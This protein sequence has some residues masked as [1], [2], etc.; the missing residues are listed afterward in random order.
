MKRYKDR[1]ECAYGNIFKFDLFRVASGDAAIYLG[2]FDPKAKTKH[3]FTL[4]ELSSPYLSD[5]STYLWLVY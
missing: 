5:G 4:I 1:S 3:S 2:T